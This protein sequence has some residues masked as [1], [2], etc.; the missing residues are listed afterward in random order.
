MLLLLYNW[1]M[2]SV[3]GFIIYYSVLLILLVNT[4]NVTLGIVAYMGLRRMV[5]IE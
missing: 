1:N 4:D 2:Y 5:N 3:N